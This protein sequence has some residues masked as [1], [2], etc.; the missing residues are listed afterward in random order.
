MIVIDWGTTNLRAYCCD[1]E[2]SIHK[3]VERPQ[4]IKSIADGTY[5]Q[6]LH[7]VLQ[8]L[9]V[10]CDHSVYI[11]GMAGSRGGWLEA[12]YCETPATL[13]SLKHSLLP[14]P[15]P[16]Y[17]FLV[18]GVRTISA[19]STIDV[20]RGE[21]V[22]IFGALD[23]FQTDNAILCLPGTHSKWVH[24]ENSQIINFS[25]FM[26][27]DIFQGLGQTILACDPNDTFD[28][29]AFELGLA[30]VEATS[31]GILHQL[32][33]ART[34]VLEKQLSYDQVS[35]FVSG[36]LIGHELVQA[37]NNFDQNETVIVIGS[38]KLCERYRV[39]LD[40]QSTRSQ[41]LGSDVATCKGI[42]GI[43]RITGEESS[44]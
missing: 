29:Q 34:R 30:A 5:P 37:K 31:G 15:A 1:D 6:V 28:Q 42:A 3:I 27:G 17:G 41:L 43:N 14:L 32:F 20:M 26:T 4:G 7:D 24:V 21:E 13:N 38:S 8:S 2:G 22:Q 35:S 33:T 36:L 18:P 9:G 11:S 16:F 10:G 40:Y 44:R 23:H 19:D 25:T 39:A 12:P